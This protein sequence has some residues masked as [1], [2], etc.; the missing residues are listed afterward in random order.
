MLGCTMLS[1]ISFFSVFTVLAT[2]IA[3]CFG[4]EFSATLYFCVVSNTLGICHRLLA[5]QEAYKYLC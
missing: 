1:V 5:S 2:Q 3:S 4:Y